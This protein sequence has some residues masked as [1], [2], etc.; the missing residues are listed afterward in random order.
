[1]RITALTLMVLMA[2]AVIGGH[3]SLAMAAEPQAPAVAAQAPD[4]DAQQPP[5]RSP[6]AS[7]GEE[8]SK[9]RRRFFPALG[10]NLKDDVTHMPRWNSVIVAGSGAIFAF[11]VHAKDPAINPHF[12][13]SANGVWKAGKIVGQMPVILG[14]GLTTYVVG[15]SVSSPRAQ[16]LGMDEIEASLLTGAI[17][18]GMK[19]AIRRDRPVGPDGQ[20]QSGFSFP[21][22]HAANAFAAATVLQQHLGYRAGVPMYALASYVAM[23]RLHD[24]KHYAS[25]VIFGS[26]VGVI[27]GRSVTWHGRHFYASP[28]LL[29]GGGGLMA[30]VRLPS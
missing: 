29:P 18:L 26:A 20:A 8:G 2:E 3:G 23:S 11:A 6:V 17:V 9:Q 7:V 14:A 25:D 15:R 13:G 12:V 27:V 28:M 1:M 21:S 19:Q 22:G 16:H 4:A 30:A 10:H 5:P 24:N